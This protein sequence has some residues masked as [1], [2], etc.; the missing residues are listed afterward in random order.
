MSVVSS[1]IV[2][3]AEKTK[4]TQ[5]FMVLIVFLILTAVIAVAV[6]LANLGFFGESELVSSFASWGLVEVLAVIIVTTVG[7]TKGLFT[8]AQPLVVVVEFPVQ[9]QESIQIKSGRYELLDI[10]SKV[11]VQG[12]LIPIPSGQGWE[13]TIPPEGWKSYYFALYLEEQ[14]GKQWAV[15]PEKT[16][17]LNHKAEVQT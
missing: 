10:Y 16:F 12:K 6:V 17:E 7:I 15:G 13:F 8:R 11:E 14:G 4:G 3:R 2:E 9:G 1:N 5:Q